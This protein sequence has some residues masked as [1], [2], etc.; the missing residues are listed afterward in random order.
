VDVDGLCFSPSDYTI[1]VDVPQHHQPPGM[2]GLDD[3]K[4]RQVPIDDRRY[5]WSE[6]RVLM[7]THSRYS[8]PPVSCNSKFSTK[9]HTILTDAKQRS[10]Y[11]KSTNDRVCDPLRSPVVSLSSCQSAVNVNVVSFTLNTSFHI[12]LR[13]TLNLAVLFPGSSLTVEYPQ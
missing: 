13:G 6:H 2:T 12:M 1:L 11:G 3:F 4:T 7:I 8:L 5:G 10:V 9:V